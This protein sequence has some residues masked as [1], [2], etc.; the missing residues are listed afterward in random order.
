MPPQ[1]TVDFDP[2]SQKYGAHFPMPP[3]AKG[4]WAAMTG[5]FLLLLHECSEV[6]EASVQLFRESWESAPLIKHLHYA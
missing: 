4:S 3:T 6:S 2:H 1:C 5:P